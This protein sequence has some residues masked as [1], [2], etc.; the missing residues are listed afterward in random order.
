MVMVLNA[1]FNNTSVIW[2]RS[3]VLVEELGVYE[4]GHLSLDLLVA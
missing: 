1:T 4:C 3:V 2:W